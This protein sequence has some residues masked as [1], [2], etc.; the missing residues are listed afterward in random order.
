[1][2][3]SGYYGLTLAFKKRVSYFVLGDFFDQFIILMVIFNTVSLAMENLGDDELKA[4][5]VQYDLFFTYTF[6]VELIL[7]VYVLGPKD[8]G[9]D[10]MN[11]FDAMIVLTSV[12]EL[13]SDFMNKDSDEEAT[14]AAKIIKN[15]KIFRMLRTLK[16]LRVLRTIKLLRALDYLQVIIEVV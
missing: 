4:K 9:R 14:G 16:T 1:M 15:A 12:M 2:W 10:K 11:L 13:V 6:I 3:I 7:K 5:R 8:Y